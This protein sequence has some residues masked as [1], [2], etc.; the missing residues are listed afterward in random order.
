MSR[1]SRFITSPLCSNL[2]YHMSA[3][4]AIWLAVL[5][6]ACALGWSQCNPSVVWT[7]AQGGLVT[8]VAHS[9]DGQWV[10]SGSLG[11]RLNIW[12]ASDGAL[13][14]SM[15]APNG[16]YAVA[17]SPDGALVA[18]GSN[19][20]VDSVYQ[21]TIW[22][23]ATG[24]LV[25]TIEE[26]HNITALAFSPDGQ[27]LASSTGGFVG[28]EIKIY[29]AIDGAL[30]RTIEGHN[31]PI[32]KMVYSPDGQHVISGSIDQTVRIWRVSD[33]APVR[34]I[35]DNDY[36]E[37]VAVSRDGQ[38]VAAGGYF[39]NRVKVWRISTGE[40][41]HTFIGHGNP[42]HSIAFAPDGFSLSSSSSDLSIKIWSMITGQL[43][44]TL[45]CGSGRRIWSV[46]YSPSG[47]AIIHGLEQNVRKSLNPYW[48]P[49]D[50]NGDRCVDDIDL[51][52]ML[53]FFGLTCL[54]CPA[55]VDGNGV[56]DDGDLATLLTNFGLGC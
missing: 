10:A 51:A 16:I 2:G 28:R 23:P 32:S 50:L 38:Y 53:E 54:G 11:W 5:C 44:R 43:L 35:S 9:P 3:M 52:L 45:E 55:D 29:R 14:R 33:G 31:G 4:K 26:T 22:N 49:G 39:D 15:L 25:R 46:A 8:S 12:R 20:N 13:L 41:V 7:Q 27:F 37:T 17:I 40:L 24:A 56:V 19:N 34:T 30:L 6:A 21:I 36:V 42:I 18:A 48:A 47:N 1:V